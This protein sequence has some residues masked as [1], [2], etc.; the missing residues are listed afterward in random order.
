M[1]EEIFTGGR[2]QR[3]EEQISCLY[4]TSIV[5]SVVVDIVRLQM[6]KKEIFTLSSREEG[7]DAVETDVTAKACQSE[8]GQGILCQVALGSGKR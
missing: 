7:K 6:G 8:C 1:L 3:S 2:P 4:C 5:S